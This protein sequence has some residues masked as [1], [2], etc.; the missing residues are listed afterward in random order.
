MIWV[1]WPKKASKIATDVTEDVIRAEA[2]KLDLVDVKVAADRRDMVGAEAGHSQG[3]AALNGPL[4]ARRSSRRRRPRRRLGIFA[5]N[6][7]R[8]P[9]RWATIERHFGHLPWPLHR[10]AAVDASRDPEG[11]LA[12]RGQIL[13][14]AAD[15]R[16]LEPVSPAHV[17]A[18]RGSLLRKPSPGVAAVPRFW[19]RAR[20]DPRGRR[21]A[22][23]GFRG[24]DARTAVR[25]ASR[26]TSSSS[27]ASIGRE[28][29]LPF[30]SAISVRQSSCARCAR[31][32]VRP[33]TC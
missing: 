1:S 6:L 30:R 9:D 10:V 4:P 14:G 7:D 24:S 20:A 8:S 19:P 28:A 33:P 3:A 2:L 23:P 16:R 15:R 22:L 12:V 31:A 25:S 17:R 32:P 13:V 29:G 18:G 11:V 5:V 27:K 21:R 26:S